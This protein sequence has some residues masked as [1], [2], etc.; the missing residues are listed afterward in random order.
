MSQTQ[1]RGWWSGGLMSMLGPARRSF[2]YDILHFT[3]YYYYYY[4]YYKIF[5]ILSTEE[6]I[7]SVP[8]VT[9]LSEVPAEVHW[10]NFHWRWERWSGPEWAFIH[11]EAGRGSVLFYVLFHCG[12]LECFVVLLPIMRGRERWTPHKIMIFF[13]LF[14][15]LLP[16]HQEKFQIQV[17]LKH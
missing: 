2:R 8:C 6:V 11:A 3:Y 5:S 13:I 17:Y 12:L 14:I 16:E 4:Y 1:A 9:L 10:L 7:V 15:Y